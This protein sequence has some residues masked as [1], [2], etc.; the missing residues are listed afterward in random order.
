VWVGL[1]LSGTTERV[2]L[3]SVGL[4]QVGPE[5]LQLGS[6]RRH[7]GAA[8]VM[9][10]ELAAVLVARA[11]AVTDGATIGRDDEEKLPV[12]HVP[13]PDGKRLVTR[14]DHPVP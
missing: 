4:S 1:E 5:E 3:T 11:G 9:F 10:Y 7:I 6:P 13:G 14:V 12:R 8:I 2:L